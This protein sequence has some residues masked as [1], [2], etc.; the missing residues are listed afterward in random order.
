MTKENLAKSDTPDSKNIEQHNGRL[1][2]ILLLL[3]V[4]GL[5]GYV[6]RSELPSDV[7]LDDNL[8]SKGRKISKRKLQFS[9][10]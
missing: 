6:L 8:L 1:K 5:V 3:L 2:Y 10:F 7:N 4:Y 9:I